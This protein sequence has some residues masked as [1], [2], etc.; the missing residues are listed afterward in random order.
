MAVTLKDVAEMAGVSRSAVSRTYT[1]GASVSKKTRDKVMRAADALGY[2]PNALA[3]SL[4]TGRTKMI[5]LVS[6]NFHNPLFLEVFD[7]FTKGLQERGLRPLLVN[8]TDRPDPYASI[9][10]LQQYSVD[11][12]IVASSTLPITF[13]ESFRD[14]GLRTVHSFGRHALA[15]SVDVLGIDNIAAGRLAAQTLIERGYTEIGFLGGPAAATSTIDREKGFLLE[16]AAHKGVAAATSFASAYSYEAGYEEMSRLLSAPLAQAY[17]C[18]DDVLSVGALAALQGAG[19]QVPQDVGLIGLN[20]M[21]MASW[22]NINLTTIRNPVSLIIDASITRVAA[23][24]LDPEI[25]PEA[26]LFDCSVVERGT[27]RPR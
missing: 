25:K 16:V 10:M 11:G 5:G 15:P 23:L 6:N 3:S 20:D 2:S 21:K 12:V 26:H 1:E 24:I 8:L 9:R 22:A 4:T 7:L 18:G 13:A 14:A 17:F 19:L 27:L